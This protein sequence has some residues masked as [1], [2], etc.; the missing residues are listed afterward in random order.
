MDGERPLRQERSLFQHHQLHTGQKEANMPKQLSMNFLT[1][2][3]AVE[4][5][6]GGATE[7]EK[8]QR[9]SHASFPEE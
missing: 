7:G 9:W 6:G 5:V 8:K 3:V 1:S 2:S 4:Q